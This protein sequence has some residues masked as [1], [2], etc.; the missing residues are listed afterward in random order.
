MGLLQE[1]MSNPND[2]QA[3]PLSGY[4]EM[5]RMN[6]EGNQQQSIPPYQSQTQQMSPQQQFQQMQQEQ[7]Q[8]QGQKLALTPEEEKVMRLCQSESFWYRS[9]PAGSLF[10]IIAHLGVQNGYLKPSPRWGSRPK[11]LLAS[12]VGYFMG[13]F[14]YVNECAD[15]FLIEAADGPVAEKIRIQR[16]MAPRG[17]HVDNDS[18]PEFKV[19][20]VNPQSP[21]FN[22]PNSPTNNP[23][24]GPP[25]QQLSGYE[26]MR[27]R[28]R[29]SAGPPGF[30]PTYQPSQQGNDQYQTLTPPPAPPS[31]SSPPSKLRPIPSS[32]NNKYGDEG[33]E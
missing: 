30:N 4:D 14:S 25:E 20:T 17:G 1:K 23:N 18:G 9:L 7:Q 2:G 31:S 21:V 27:R 19:I 24:R 15:K 5:R 10:S 26:E 13:K 28:N 33:F 22:N 6:R 16:G 3:P 29:E 32:G 8:F 12:V 11:V